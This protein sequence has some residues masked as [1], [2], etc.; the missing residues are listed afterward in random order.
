MIVSGVLLSSRAKRGT[1]TGM[2][3]RAGPS[4]RSGR[5]DTSLQQ[6]LRFHDR[7]VGRAIDDVDP[8]QHERAADELERRDALAKQ[9]PGQ[10]R[11]EGGLTEQGDG[12]ARD[13]YFYGYG[14]HREMA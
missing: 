1:C 6:R 5:H 2:T 13:F 14:G 7:G 8:G 3:A 4:H 11:G 9:G 10:N 12:G